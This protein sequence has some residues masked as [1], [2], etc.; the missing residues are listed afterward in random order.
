MLYALDAKTGKIHYRKEL[1]IPSAGGM[2]GMEAANIYGSLTMAGRHL[3]L[4][5]DRGLER[6]HFRGPKRATY[7]VAECNRL[8]AGRVR[9]M[10]FGRG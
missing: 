6:G 2:P 5:V 1:S 4:T 8:E 10:R 9:I 3:L 7:A